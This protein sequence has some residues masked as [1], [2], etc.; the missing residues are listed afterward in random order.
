MPSFNPRE[1]SKAAV[2]AMAEVK[3]ILNERGL[4]HQALALMKEVLIQLTRRD[5]LFPSDV[6]CPMEHG[7][8]TNVLYC[9]A[10]DPDGTNA[11]YLSSERHSE[12]RS[13]LPHNHLTW[14]VIVGVEGKE[15]NKLYERTDDGSVLGKG[16]VCQTGEVELSRETGIYLMPEEIHSVHAK[17]G[18]TMLSMHVYGLS[19]PRQTERI[20]FLPDGTTRNRKPNTNI[21]PIPGLS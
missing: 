13:T 5:G 21:R 15:L 9:L 3:F 17:G 12:D 8:N 16:A 4:N 2:V 20:E 6:F 1:T 7:Q 11:L 18:S 14:A 19:M 10:E